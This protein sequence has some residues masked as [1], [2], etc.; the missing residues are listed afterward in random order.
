MGWCVLEGDSY[1]Q[2]FFAA[3]A[4]KV[5]GKTD[6]LG[7]QKLYDKVCALI[8]EFSPEKVVLELPFY[9]TNA[10]VFVRLGEARGAILLACAHKTVS[11]DSVSPNEAKMAATGSGHATKEQVAY[12]VKT[13]LHLSGDFPVDAT[14][15][16]A[17]GIAFFHRHS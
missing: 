3:G 5:S 11:C 9:G 1:G 4:E 12:M 16:A 8:D 15:A 10:K 13:L 6:S 14:D 2:T 7:L 17:I